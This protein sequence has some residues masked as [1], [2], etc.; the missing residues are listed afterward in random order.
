MSVGN[1]LYTLNCQSKVTYQ[2]CDIQMICIKVVTSKQTN[3]APIIYLYTY[4]S[5]NHYQRFAHRK[6]TNRMDMQS[7]IVSIQS[8]D[9]TYLP[10][11]SAINYTIK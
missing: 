7:N 2:N 4:K 10:D 9:K 1:E 5:L 6:T 8:T 11:L 3:V